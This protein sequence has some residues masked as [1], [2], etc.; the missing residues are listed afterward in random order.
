MTGS[1]RFM[2]L[3]KLANWLHEL[4]RSTSLEHMILGFSKFNYSLGIALRTALEVN[5]GWQFLGYMVHF[6]FVYAV[7]ATK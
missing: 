1:D 5:E 3:N 6:R 2:L 7:I 4:L